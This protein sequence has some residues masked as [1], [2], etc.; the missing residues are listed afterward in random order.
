[1][2][3][4]DEIRKIAIAKVA[5]L[6]KL[7]AARAALP[8]L[9]EAAVALRDRVAANRRELLGDPNAA[10][11]QILAIDDDLKRRNLN[12]ERFDALV[13][14]IDRRIDET[15][16]SNRRK[17]LEARRLAAT[18]LRDE[19]IASLKSWDDRCKELA[20]IVVRVGEARAAVE[21][22]NAALAS[23]GFEGEPLLEPEAFRQR[24]ALPA[25]IVSE[26]TV[27][28]WV[29]FGTDRPV[30]W[31]NAAQAQDPT[32][33]VLKL[34]NGTKTTAVAWNEQAREFRYTA[35]PGADYDVVEKRR[36]K[37]RT[38]RRRVAF[39]APPA[40]A[41][42]LSLPSLI[43]HVPHWR[44]LD[45]ADGRFVVA[46]AAEIAQQAAKTPSKV[47]REIEIIEEIMPRE[48]EQ[49]Q[50]TA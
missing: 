49:P 26:D 37:K 4:F 20:G 42:S 39:P 29:Y 12:I 32:R 50:A 47:T 1:M 3:T 18:K 9:R 41:T 11:E 38:M 10:D 17:D 7:Q 30:V 33:V 28:R 40:L 2:M 6:A 46:A 14:D 19:A 43:G 16:L 23:S 25:E 24:T 13:E 15:A 35:W 48:Q 5:D 45:Y 8:G 21:A 34:P 31:H 27:E 36:F 44:P 22:F